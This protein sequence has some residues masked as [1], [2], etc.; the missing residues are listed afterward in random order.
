VQGAGLEKFHKALEGPSGPDLL[1][2][3]LKDAPG[4]P[5]LLGI[6]DVQLVVGPLFRMDLP[7][8]STCL[9]PALMSLFGC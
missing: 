5:E 1:A 6:W 7:T 8:R 9:M 2:S 3:Y 4:A